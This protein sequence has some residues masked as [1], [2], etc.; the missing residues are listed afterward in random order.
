MWSDNETSEDLLG[1]KVHADLLVQVIEDET[2]LPVT[3]GLFAD[4]GGGKSSIMKMIMNELEKEDNKSSTICLYFNGWSFEGYE[5]A[6]SALISSILVQ[7]GEHKTWKGKIKDEVVGLLKRVQWMN[8][9][10]YGIKH[11]GI[12]L[13]AG[14]LTGGAGTIPAVLGSIIN[15]EKFS[16]QKDEEKNKK[17]NSLNW[18]ECQ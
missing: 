11:I 3:I 14:A 17:D 18:W 8:L 9:A 13:V 2:I 6:K 16:N 5:D 12:P 15:P 7:L 4:W 1:F 10:K